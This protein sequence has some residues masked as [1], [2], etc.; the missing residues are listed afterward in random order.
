MVSITTAPL[1]A[2]ENPLNA[3][4]GASAKIHMVKP[5]RNRT[6]RGSYCFIR[7]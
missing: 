1:M 4:M 7:Q 3:A 2:D 6:I 5:A